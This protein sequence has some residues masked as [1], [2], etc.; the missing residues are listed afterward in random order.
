MSDTLR[1]NMPLLDAAQA[2][3]HVTINEALVRADVLAARR[4][5]SMS[6][7]VAPEAPLDGTAYIVGNSASGDWTGSDRQ[8]ALFSN[9]GW[10]IISPWDGLRLW[11]EDSEATAL[12]R[13]GA[14]HIDALAVSTSLASTSVSVVEIDHV[15]APS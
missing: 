4:V 5:E 2:Q 3:K 1:F 8:I 14:W 6:F 7:S 11:V 12:Y 15:L 10:I 9:G 13:G